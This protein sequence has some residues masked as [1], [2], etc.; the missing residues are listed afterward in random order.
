MFSS[1]SAIAFGVT[2]TILIL[3]NVGVG[4]AIVRYYKKKAAKR[5]CETG[6]YTEFKDEIDN[7]RRA[8]RDS[9]SPPADAYEFN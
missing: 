4:T 5:K 8:M 2:V 1:V 6:D 3:A 9:M 7:D